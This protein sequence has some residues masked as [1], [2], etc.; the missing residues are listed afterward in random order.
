MSDCIFCKI[1]SGELGTDF[2]FEDDDFVAFKDINPKSKTHVLVVPKR[3]LDSLAE[4]SESDR[5]MLGNALLVC[6][7]VAKKLELPGYNVR[8]NVGKAGGQE[9]FHIHFHL[10]SN[11]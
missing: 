4:A 5:G 7:K 9:V 3:H 1:V 2:L 8:L 10:M 11:F 6:Q